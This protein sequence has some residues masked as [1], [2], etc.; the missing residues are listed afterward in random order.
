MIDLGEWLSEKRLNHS[1]RVAQ[2]AVI[3]AKKHRCRLDWAFEAGIYHDIAKELNLEDLDKL[4]IKQ[5]RL[6]KSIY[7]NYFPVWHAFIA[8]Y[9][10]KEVC[11]IRNR[12]ILQAIRW[13]TTGRANMTL[14][15]KVIFIADYIEPGRSVEDHDHLIQL[16]LKDIDGAV[17]E[18]IKRTVERVESKNAKVHPFSLACLDY[19]Q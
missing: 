2:T 9:I 12:E 5:S 13:H 17:G 7:K 4:G 10:L 6:T 14:L 8:P 16:A 18:I 11:N 15:E 1:H 3:L 19:Y